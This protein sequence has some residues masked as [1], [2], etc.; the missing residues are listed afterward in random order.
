MKR[1]FG[2]DGIRGVAGV[3]LTA[4]VAFRIGAAFAR[5]LMNH[6]HPSPCLLVVRDTRLSGRMLEEAFARG[7]SAAGG[8]VAL[9]GILPT[10]AASHL[11]RTE[12]FTASA[13]ISASHNPVQFNGIKLFNPAGEKLAPEEEEE[14]EELFG[15]ESVAGGQEA[16]TGPIR[17]FPA[18]REKY[19][20]LLL[21]RYTGGPLSKHRIA[22]DC[23][24]G[25]TAS[26]AP[27]IF[28]RLGASLT[29]YGSHPD[30]SR[31][32]VNCGSTHFE[33][34]SRLTL[35]H[36]CQVGF[37]FDG[38]GDRLI[39]SDE[40]GQLFDGDNLLASFILRKFAPSLSPDPSSPVPHSSFA[41]LVVGTPY[42]NYGLEQAL[43]KRG[44]RLIRAPVGDRF[45]Y[46]EVKKHH[47][48]IGGE[49]SGHI[50]FNG[51]TTTGDGILSALLLLSLL[52]Q[53]SLPLSLL[54]TDMHRYPQ[55][56]LN[57]P[58][59]PEWKEKYSELP[60]A[61]QAVQ[62]AEEKLRSRGRL[63]I[64]PS[65]TENLLRILV[66]ADDEILA[67]STAQALADVLRNQE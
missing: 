64:R 6:H 13:S 46:Q 53:L 10:P 45:V 60:K 15:Q 11:Q 40:A 2:T 61:Q 41:P 65:G 23:A 51:L 22:L 14:I 55:V 17:S 34:L 67:K 29:L 32:N 21:S 19:I 36:S 35:K 16:T 25:A 39:S 28:H 8:E 9:A 12:G 20:S 47:A 66:E 48:P 44:F 49:P 1:L 50:V 42:S 5:F 37:A 31:I 63:F 62:S 33:T 43:Q 56:L 30:G 38:D 7:F 18:A 57:L 52:Q 58:V 24:Y 54:Q 4:E 26:V 3:D 27:E 59:S